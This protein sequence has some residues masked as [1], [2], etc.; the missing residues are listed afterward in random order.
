MSD[1]KHHS[2]TE[3]A[4]VAKTSADVKPAHPHSKI[5]DAKETLLDVIHDVSN[6]LSSGIDASAKSAEG[7]LDNIESEKAEAEAAVAAKKLADA[8]AHADKKSAEAAEA[9][10]K[11][12]AARIEAQRLSVLAKSKSTTKAVE[13][14]KHKE[15]VASGSE[16]ESPHNLLDT[17]MEAS[18]NGLHKVEVLGKALSAKMSALSDDSDSASAS[19]A[20]QITLTS[21]NDASKEPVV[22]I[23]TKAADHHETKGGEELSKD[24]KESHH[25]IDEL[26]AASKA[27]FEKI[28]H[29]GELLKWKLSTPHHKHNNEKTHNENKA[30]V[31]K[32]IEDAKHV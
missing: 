23:K 10:L 20:T 31:I 27:G 32:P 14:V 6:R 12:V 30:D 29:L 19:G 26:V 3:E 15:S 13:G 8:E 28:E 5:E 24:T 22:V 2:E 17:I 16:D 9:R 11:V 1:N 25:M 7:F 21:T 4:V 18:K